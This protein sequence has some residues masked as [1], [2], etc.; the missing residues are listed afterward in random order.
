[1]SEKQKTISREANF[2]GKAL[3]TGRAVNV[4]C[5]PSGPDSGIIFK[6]MDLDGQP[7]IRVGGQMLSEGPSRRSTIG[8]GEAEIQTVEHFL[9]ALWGVGVDNVLVEIDGEELP[10]FD[11]SALTFLKGLKEAGSE[12]QPAERRT[13]KVLEPQRVEEGGSSLAVFP[14]GGFSIDYLID[15][16]V[17]SI[18]REN[19]HIELNSESF[20]R[21]IAPARTFCLRKEAEALLRAGLGQ[22]ANLDNTLVMDEE[23][24]IGTTLRF[25]DEPVRHKVLDLVGDLYMLGRPVAGRFVA[26]KS[27]HAVN[28][29]MVRI[30]YEK[31]IVGRS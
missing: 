13:I 23:G 3:Q 24:P 17:A 12:D 15:Y 10:A 20:E 18:G 14:D 8:L 19:F 4:V 7:S 21:E 31:Y 28:A 29:R 5:K 30:I 27:G 22:G 25:P 1:M 6:R 11:G 2:S 9:A 16:D 26:E